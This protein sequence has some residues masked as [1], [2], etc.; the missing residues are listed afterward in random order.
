[1]A[2]YQDYID[3]TKLRGTGEYNEAVIN[4]LF[5]ALNKH[6]VFIDSGDDSLVDEYDTVKTVEDFRTFCKIKGI[7]KKI[8]VEATI[9]EAEQGYVTMEKTPADPEDD[10][11]KAAELL[12]NLGVPEVRIKEIQEQN[13]RLRDK[14]KKPIQ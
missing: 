12:S 14:Q 10:T 8:D 9:L 2:E 7:D 5:G 4:I 13:K 6:G 3:I 11:A 1:M